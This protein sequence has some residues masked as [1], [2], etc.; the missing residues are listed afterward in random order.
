MSHIASAKRKEPVKQAEPVQKPHSD[1]RCFFTGCSKPGCFG[2]GVRLRSGIE[3]RWACMDHRDA[4]RAG[5]FEC[6]A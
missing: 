4:V 6:A 2:F 3:S 1:W 5:N